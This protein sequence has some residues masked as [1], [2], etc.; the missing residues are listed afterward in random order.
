[1]IASENWI[2]DSASDQ[3]I[4]SK[5]AS[6]P[7]R[8]TLIYR[9]RGSPPPFRAIKATISQV[10]SYRSTLNQPAK[11]L[12]CRHGPNQAYRIVLKEL[13][14]SPSSLTSKKSDS[15]GLGTNYWCSLWFPS[16]TLLFAW[17]DKWN[18]RKGPW[19]DHL[20]ATSAH[21]QFLGGIINYHLWFNFSPSTA[22]FPPDTVATSL[23]SF[24]QRQ[25]YQ[26]CHQS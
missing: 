14:K 3:S 24:I 23:Q 6:M 9:V 19:K 22:S 7:P 1:V 15:G 10:P 26:K 18:V 21:D 5:A 11:H 16:V 17:S 12:F 4:E 8:W 20:I 13:I 25:S 2:A